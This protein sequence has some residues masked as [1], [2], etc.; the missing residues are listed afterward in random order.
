MFMRDVQSWIK[1]RCFT[2]LC[3]VS[4]IKFIGMHLFKRVETNSLFVLP[5][6]KQPAHNMTIDDPFKK[7]KPGEA[8]LGVTT[9]DSYSHTH[10][11]PQSWLCNLQVALLLEQTVAPPLAHTLPIASPT[12]SPKYTTKY[13]VVAVEVLP[14]HK[15]L[16]T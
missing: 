13:S 6:S 5:S 4:S 12:N 14:T 9:D 8:D 3:K 16:P 10:N 1:F 15:L 11:R 2:L 7:L